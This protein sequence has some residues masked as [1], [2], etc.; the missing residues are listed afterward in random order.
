MLELKVGES[1]VV[2][3]RGRL[4]AAESE[5]ALATLAT[6]PGPLTLDC[7]QLEYISSAGIRVILLTVQRLAAAGSTLT[8]A[9]MLPAVRTVFSYAGLERVLDIR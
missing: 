3:L 8:L 6:L 4:D 2:A 5:R 9:G 1:G 7:S